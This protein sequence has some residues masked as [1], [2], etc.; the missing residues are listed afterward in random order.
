ML[1]G[2]ISKPCAE[3]ATQAELREAW[4]LRMQQEQRGPSA[5]GATKLHAAFCSWAL[6]G[7]SPAAALRERG[8]L[9]LLA[10]CY[11]QVRAA[12]V[13]VQA[14][15]LQVRADTLPDQHMHVAALLQRRQGA[16]PGRAG[17]VHNVS[18][19]HLLAWCDP[20]MR[21]GAIPGLCMHVGALLQAAWP[22]GT[23]TSAHCQR[24]G[25]TP[26]AS[27]PGCVLRSRAQQET[28]AARVQHCTYA[29]RLWAPHLIDG[30]DAVL[31]A[32]EDARAGLAMLED[33][34]PLDSPTR[35]L[36][37]ALHRLRGQACL[38]EPGHACRDAAAAVQVGR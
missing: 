28:P 4:F 5:A 27:W 3:Q 13:Q 11:L 14:A 9:H 36:L 17:I 2:D 12:S 38:A 1:Q 8:Q 34:A 21:A 26:A 10:H 19:Q 29:D 7:L 30:F 31:Q 22:V 23:A 35:R 33:S 25:P 24:A 15:A 37:G 20:Q 18:V 32:A 6:D 16:R